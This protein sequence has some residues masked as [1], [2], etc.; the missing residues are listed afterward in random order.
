MPTF[1]QRSYHR[2]CQRKWVGGQKMQPPRSILQN[3]GKIVV[4]LVLPPLAPLRTLQ[5]YD[6]PRISKRDLDLDEIDF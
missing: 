3:Q 5:I 1:C 6:D 4:L 2:K